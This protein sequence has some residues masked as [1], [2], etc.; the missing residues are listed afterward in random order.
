[1]TSEIKIIINYYKKIDMNYYE[2]FIKIFNNIS[3]KKESDLIDNFFYISSIKANNAHGII[4]VNKSYKNISNDNLH[5]NNTSDKLKI[6]KSNLDHFSPNRNEKLSNK[7]PDK[8]YIK[9]PAR[10]KK[11]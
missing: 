2:Y 3:I 10:K 9:S 5:L 6:N 8:I 7:T 4:T 11:M 1:M